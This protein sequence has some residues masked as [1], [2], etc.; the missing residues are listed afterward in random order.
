MTRIASDRGNRLGEVHHGERSEHGWLARLVG[1]VP[2]FGRGSAGQNVS[3][4][5]FKALGSIDGIS[6]N[7]ID[8]VQFKLAYKLS[9]T[10]TRTMRAAPSL[11]T[12]P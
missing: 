11:P 3:R 2:G 9:M 4:F 1:H 10:R 6:G 5:T 7:L 8:D 12:R